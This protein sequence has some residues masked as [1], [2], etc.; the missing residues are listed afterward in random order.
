M[1]QSFI[2]LAWQL[3][4]GTRH[5]AVDTPGCSTG[6]TKSIGG[7][8]SSWSTRKR[9]RTHSTLFRTAAMSTADLILVFF[10]ALG[11]SF[12][13]CWRGSLGFCQS[14]RETKPPATSP[15][16]FTSCWRGSLGFCQSPRETE[17]PA[18]SPGSFSSCRRGRPRGPVL[19]L[20]R[21][22]LPSFRSRGLPRPRPLPRLQTSWPAPLPQPGGRQ[23]AVPR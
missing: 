7:R 11:H 4:L 8:W 16:S 9:R 2:F 1:R 23:N 5:L 10:Q 15:C 18:T 14:P 19:P 6:D 17:P 20:G 12:T 13:S 3:A 22:S 21:P